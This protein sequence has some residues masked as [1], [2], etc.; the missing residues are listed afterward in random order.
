[1]TRA[2]ARIRVEVSNRMHGRDVY[3]FAA[4]TDLGRLLGKGWYTE[5]VY[6][7]VLNSAS[8]GWAV[9]IGVDAIITMRLFLSIGCTV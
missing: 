6:R 9:W 7:L 4:V 2:S 3:R 1:M 5:R 8:V